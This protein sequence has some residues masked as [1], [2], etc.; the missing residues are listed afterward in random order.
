[1]CMTTPNDPSQQPP[2]GY[3]AYPPQ[4]AD[5]PA[6][7]AGYPPPPGTGYPPPGAGY[8]P[9]G[10]GYPPPAAYPPPP[11]GSY[12][13][14]P[15]A[16]YPP[17]GAGYRQPWTPAR[18]PQPVGPPVKPPPFVLVTLIASALALVGAVAPWF[19]PVIGANPITGSDEI[20]VWDDGRLGLIGPLLLVL[21]GIFWLSLFLRPKSDP[22]VARKYATLTLVAGIVGLVSV[23]ILWALVPHNYTDW[24]AAKD[25]AQARGLS[26]GRGPKLGFWATVAAAVIDLLLGAAAIVAVR[27]PPRMGR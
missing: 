16:S 11:P 27:R 25:A 3:E 5:F 23:A 13:P 22:S 24:D 7:G 9:P 10:A 15:G 21:V 19:H 4:A 1:M 20:R 6:P 8:P 12:P 18:P 2:A 26:L 17:P 14:A